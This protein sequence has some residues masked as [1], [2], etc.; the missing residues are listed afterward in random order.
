[1]KLQFPR[2]MAGCHVAPP[3][4]E[5]STP[6]T[7]PPPASLAV[8]LTVT[9]LPPCRFAPAAG[10]VMV[11]VGGVWSVEAVAGVKPVCNVAGWTPMSANKLTVACCMLGSGSGAEEYWES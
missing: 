9:G 10:E 2:P 7:T 4:S 3:S 5:T 6:P 8:P 11:E 1:V